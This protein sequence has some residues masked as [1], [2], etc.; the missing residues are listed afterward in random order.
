MVSRFP[1]S[2]AHLS[3]G[4]VLRARHRIARPSSPEAAEEALA[5]RGGLSVLAFG[6]GRSYGDSCLNPD[7][8]LIE[9][10]GL[11]R[12]LAFDPKRGILRAEAGVSLADLLATVVGRPAPDGGVWCLPVSPGTRFVTLGGAVANDVHGKNHGVAGSFGRHVRALTLLR[13]D[14]GRV[15]CTPEHNGELFRATIGGLGL[16]GLILEV[17]LQLERLEG[18]LLEVEEIRFE[19]LDGFYRLAEESAGWTYTVAWVDCLARG[20]NLGRGIFSRARHLPGGAEHVERP[21]PPRLSVPVTPP[22]S[23]LGR[24]TLTAFNTLIWQRL[25]SA[26]RRVRT[27]PWHRFLYP[28]DSIGAWNRLYG[29]RGFWQYQCV[30]P[31]PEAPRAVARLLE[32]IAHSGQGSFLAVLK[33]MG[34]LPSP[35][36]LSFPMEGTTLALDFPNRGSP[37]LELLARLDRIVLE[38]GGR[39]YAAKDGRMP[40][41]LFR[42]GYPNWRAFAELVDPA[43][44][45]AFWRRVDTADE[46]AQVMEQAA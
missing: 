38:A 1:E 39:L 34:P 3:W 15:E 23:P 24:A 22:L 42:A 2:E 45:S 6:L 25:G 46:R 14:R 19:D 30:V 35:G 36:L 37:T 27:V 43:F 28:L 20:R 32:T 41:H 16:T 26:G 21:G 31:P 33:T 12:L 7:G 44:S 4:R 10:R 17:T 40:A 11:D 18:L 5:R 9:T 29:P 13:S 8:L